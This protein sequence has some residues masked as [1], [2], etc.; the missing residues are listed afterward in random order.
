MQISSTYSISTTGFTFQSATKDDVR[1]DHYGQVNIA[2]T[3]M[4]NSW[5]ID[6]TDWDDQWAG[7][8]AS[9]QEKLIPEKGV[10]Y[11]IGSRV[12]FTVFLN[13]DRVR[14]LLSMADERVMPSVSVPF[15]LSVET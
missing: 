15:Y 2:E 13:S 12:H 7:V 8:D 6:S 9:D 5:A 10:N 1:L 4:E 11:S 14:P 3:C